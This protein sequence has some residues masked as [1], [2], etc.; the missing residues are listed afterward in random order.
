MVSIP[1]SKPTNLRNV[2]RW[3]WAQGD[4]MPNPTHQSVLLYLSVHSFY[5]DTEEAEMG[6]VFLGDSYTEAIMSGT[7]IKSRTTVWNTLNSLQDMG[8]LW[9]CEREASNPSKK[10]QLPHE[11]YVLY[12]DKFEALREHLR[13]GHPLPVKLRDR[14][15][16]KPRTATVVELKTF[17]K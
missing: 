13:A 12:E 5:R 4:H 6:Q 2:L 7:A 9:R 11:I 16:L 10:G 17:R 14:P 8:Y 3:V 1:E 15:R